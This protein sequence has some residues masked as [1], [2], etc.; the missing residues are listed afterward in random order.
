MRLT[1]FSSLSLL[2][3]PCTSPVT[4]R[5]IPLSVRDAPASLPRVTSISY[6]GEGCPSSAPDVERTGAG[7]GDIG[8]RLNGFE[9]KLPG[10]DTSSTNCQVHLQATG[11]TAGWQVGIHDA[12]IKGHLVLD[13]GASV[14]WYL[15]SFWSE[16]AG[17]TTTI[18]GTIANNGGGRTDQDV[19]QTANA[20]P[21][22]WS[23]CSKSDGFLGT[24]NVNFRVALNAAGNQYGY[25]GKD[26]DTAAAESWSY[27]WR[28]C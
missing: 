15:T 23:P 11:C 25:F 28:R 26:S 5:S 16:D 20:S 4:A 18:S 6:S 2:L 13:P 24:L 12:T 17:D 9:A 19:S 14:T 1:G 10:I 7:F 22:A 3:L 21:I 8:F 27:V